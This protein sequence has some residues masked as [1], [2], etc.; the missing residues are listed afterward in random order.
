MALCDTAKTHKESPLGT[1]FFRMIGDLL[2]AGM[3]L[4]T[5]PRID[6]L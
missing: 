4:E 3:R 6:R 5:A 1:I 2:T